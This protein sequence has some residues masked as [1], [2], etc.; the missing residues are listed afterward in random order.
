MKGFLLLAF[1][2][3]LRQSSDARSSLR[4]QAGED[5]LVLMVMEFLITTR[6]ALWNA[7][8]QI[9]LFLL[10]ASGQLQRNG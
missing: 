6:F 3:H 2:H 1:V 5:V 8:L 9:V 4:D 10:A 7:N